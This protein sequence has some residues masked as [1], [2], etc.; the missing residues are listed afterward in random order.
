MTVTARDDSEFPS[1]AGIDQYGNHFLL[2]DPVR[3]AGVGR[4]VTVTA[5]WQKPK[6]PYRDIDYVS[7]DAVLSY[8]D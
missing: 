3:M 7:F 6:Y 1:L 5:E 4:P 8:L 2:L